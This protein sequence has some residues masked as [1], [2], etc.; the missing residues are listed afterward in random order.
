M[1]ILE[2]IWTTFDPYMTYDK[3][4]YIEVVDPV[5]EFF[6]TTGTINCFYV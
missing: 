1:M 6:C 4:H 5:V 3:N 2:S